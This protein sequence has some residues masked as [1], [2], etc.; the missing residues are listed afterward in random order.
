[1]MNQKKKER[2]VVVAFRADPLLLGELES[3]CKDFGLTKSEVIRTIFNQNI[4]LPK[5]ETNQN[6]FQKSIL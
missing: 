5:A 2:L 6:T 1:M 4:Y 3:H